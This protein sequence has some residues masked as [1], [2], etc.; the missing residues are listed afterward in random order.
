MLQ[1]CRDI[2]TCNV[3][4]RHSRPPIASPT[5]NLKIIS[6]VFHIFIPSNSTAKG[7]DSRNLSTRNRRSNP[8]SSPDRQF[9]VH[10]PD[11]HAY[12]ACGLDPLLVPVVIRGD[13]RNR[14]MDRSHLK[15]EQAAMEEERLRQ[16]CTFKPELT[17][18]HHAAS[19]GAQHATAG[20]DESGRGSPCLKRRG[21]VAPRA[22]SRYRQAAA[23]IATSAAAAGNGSSGGGES[24][25]GGGGGSGWGIWGAGR[26][27]SMPEEG[28]SRD[29]GLDGCTFSPAVIGARKG[30]YQAQR[31]LQVCFRAYLCMFRR[32][33]ALYHPRGCRGVIRSLSWGACRV[34]WR[35][36]TP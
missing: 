21:L 18:V 13:P 4:S 25:E 34:K 10:S 23:A 6:K 5:N 12:C 16:E 30:M 32:P 24:G 9:S 29:W 28:E 27:F 17:V 8:C 15:A 22:R 2:P 19:A 36:S 33:R 35:E 26:R 11:R 31:Y 3:G 14:D 20:I 1:R 7:G